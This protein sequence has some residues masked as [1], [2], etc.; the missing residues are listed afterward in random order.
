[1][2]LAATIYANQ[3]AKSIFFERVQLKRDES[4][5]D[6]A[7]LDKLEQYLFASR[8]VSRNA[9]G[10]LVEP[11]AFCFAS[12]YLLPLGGVNLPPLTQLN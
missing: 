3:D 9:C 10:E 7:V 8:L 1:M 4:R 6:L 11:F 5:S 12:I 2:N